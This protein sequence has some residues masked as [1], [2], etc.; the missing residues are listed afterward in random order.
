M[1][2]KLFFKDSSLFYSSLD[3][4][5][6]LL[7]TMASSICATPT[8][9]W[10]TTWRGSSGRYS[11]RCGCLQGRNRT[12]C[13][14]NT[15]TR[16]LKLVNQGKDRIRKRAGRSNK[17]AI[18]HIIFRTKPPPLLWR[19]KKIFSDLPWMADHIKFSFPTPSC[20]HER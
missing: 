4:N 10:R 3:L 18:A 13:I 12:D 5:L 1:F 6:E 11:R 16:H 19:K 20:L 2:K 9:Y 15:K 8:E 17:S 14:F 7:Q